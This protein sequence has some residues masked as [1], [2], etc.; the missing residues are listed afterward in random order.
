VAG[1]HHGMLR[2]PAVASLAE[3]LDRCIVAG[4]AVTGPGD[5]RLG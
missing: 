4:L 3:C 5:S 2:E 1:S